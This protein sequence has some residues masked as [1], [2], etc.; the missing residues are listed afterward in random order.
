MALLQMIKVF[1]F[2]IGLLVVLLFLPCFD[3]GGGTDRVGS[4]EKPK[5]SGFPERRL[6][7]RDA[8]QAT[9]GNNI[10]FAERANRSKPGLS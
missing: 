10:N 9:I 4:V 1:Q 7:L 6:S 5:Q 2:T 3:L 8:I